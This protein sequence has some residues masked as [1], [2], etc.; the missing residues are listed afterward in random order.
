[1]MLEPFE[2]K[3]VIFDE[4]QG[5]VGPCAV[6]LSSLLMTQLL[7]VKLQRLLCINVSTRDNRYT[8]MELHFI[9]CCIGSRYRQELPKKDEQ[10]AFFW[11][12]FAKETEM[13]DH[14]CTH[15]TLLRS[16]PTVLQQID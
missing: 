3:P 11:N 7:S 6:I 2:Y 9:C 5:K 12:I 15:A 10:F 13:C 16:T 1:M 14:L 8:D 4:L